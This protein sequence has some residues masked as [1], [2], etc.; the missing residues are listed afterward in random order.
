MD[1]NS[2]LTNKVYFVVLVLA[3]LK[4]VIIYSAGRSHDLPNFDLYYP[5]VKEWIIIILLITALYIV[6]T[7][8]LVVSVGSKKMDQIMNQNY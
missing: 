1:L 5:S 7:M 2:C 4:A 8:F 6:G 3:I